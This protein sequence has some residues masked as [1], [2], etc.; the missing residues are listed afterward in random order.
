MRREDGEG[1]VTAEV[2]ISGEPSPLDPVPDR[3]WIPDLPLSI[4][5]VWAY[6]NLHGRLYYR[7]KTK[8]GLSGRGP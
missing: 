5:L 2:D 7:L 8:P 6:Q 4:R 1:F 3:F